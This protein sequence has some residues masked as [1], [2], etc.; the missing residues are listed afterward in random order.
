MLREKLDELYRIK[1]DPYGNVI[2]CENRIPC[3]P[4]C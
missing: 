2:L 4:V 3:Q 1:T